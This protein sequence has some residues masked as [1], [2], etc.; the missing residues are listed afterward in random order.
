MKKIV[1]I[2]GALVMFTSCT[3]N[4]ICNTPTK[5]QINKAMSYSSW[6]YVMPKTQH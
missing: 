5:K 4:K 2:V 6:E 1:I 3:T